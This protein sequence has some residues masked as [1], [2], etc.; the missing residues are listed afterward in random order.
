MIQMVIILFNLYIHTIYHAGRLMEL[1]M[2]I[3]V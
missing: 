2:F 3:D 1:M